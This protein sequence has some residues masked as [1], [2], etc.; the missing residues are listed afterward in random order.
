MSYLARQ[1][2]LTSHVSSKNGVFRGAQ[3]LYYFWKAHAAWAALN[4]T[5]SFMSIYS[6]V[7]LCAKSVK[8]LTCLNTN[9]SYCYTALIC[10]ALS[11]I[12][13]MDMLLVHLKFMC[14]VE[15]K[16]AFLVSIL[17]RL[18]FSACQILSQSSRVDAMWF[19]SS[20]FLYGS[21]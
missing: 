17:S 20:G 8:C 11:T 2:N 9:L 19:N 12:S 21:L 1:E 6:Y 16:K 10:M 13:Y 18:C 4:D 14:N 15:M 5:F 3:S 7:S